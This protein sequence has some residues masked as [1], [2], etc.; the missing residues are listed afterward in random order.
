MN[1]AHSHP[2][3][4]LFQFQTPMLRVCYALLPLLLGSIYLFGWRS[5]LLVSVVFIFGIGTEALF[6]I[7]IGKPVT[8]AVFV[9][10]LIFSLSLPPMTTFWM[11]AIGIIFGVAIG[12]M[13]FGGF[14]QN[15]FNPAMVGRCFIYVTFP[16]Q[17]TNIWLEPMW[18]GFA[19][20]V[21][22]SNSVDAVTKATPLISLK[23]GAALNWQ[24]LFLGH[25]PGSLGETSAFLI[26]LGGAYII[27]K[28]AAP[29]RLALSCLLGGVLISSILFLSGSEVIP[30]PVHTLLAGSFLFGCA[31]VV[32]EPI[33]GAKTN[34]GQWI[35]GS[36][37]GG[38][39][40]ILRGFSNF[41]EGIMFSV[42]IMNAFVPI[43]DQTIRQI[44]AKREQ[45]Q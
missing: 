21:R 16:K 19:G 28:K 6:M 37:I 32:T 22:W 29:W 45:Q 8:S 12:K 24:D 42:L 40:V 26:L 39:T 20:L 9:T 27:Y 3:K 2:Q 30:S 43:M 14:G 41:S 23:E 10:C 13:V 4:E 36:M 18:G 38:L 44:Q 11:A 34:A 17:M 15:I 35:Y 31:F 25:I 7:R 5:L 1:P 33:S